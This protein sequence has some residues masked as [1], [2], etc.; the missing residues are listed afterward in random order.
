MV[1][2]L[3]NTS[4]SH[5][6]GHLLAL[7][8]TDRSALTIGVAVAIVGVMAREWHEHRKAMASELE[9]DWEHERELEL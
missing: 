7:S 3:V 2:A 5:R 1:I 9:H 6:G 8:S 4:M